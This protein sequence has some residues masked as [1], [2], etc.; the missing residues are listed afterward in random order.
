ME[1]P[2][3]LWKSGISITVATATTISISAKASDGVAN[4]TIDIAPK[5]MDN[6]AAHLGFFLL[7]CIT[8]GESVCASLIS[9]KK[10]SNGSS[11]SPSTMYERKNENDNTRWSIRQKSSVSDRS[12]Y[13]FH[14]HVWGHAPRF[15]EFTV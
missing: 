11:A 12:W 7:V 15:N 13:Q 4:G 3:D 8:S 6:I 5:V 1:L 2:S 14:A 9:A 10:Q